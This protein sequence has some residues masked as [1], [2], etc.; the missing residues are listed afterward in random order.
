M[1]G[2]SVIFDL[3]N[4]L[5]LA[6]NMMFSVFIID[7]QGMFHDLFLELHFSIPSLEDPVPLEMAL[8]WYMEIFSE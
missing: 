5:T 8:T 2:N 1:Y 3:I 6:S 4:S 7:C